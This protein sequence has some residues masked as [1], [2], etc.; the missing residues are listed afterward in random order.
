MR[1]ALL[2]IIVFSICSCSNSSNDNSLNSGYLV[3]KII[4]SSGS[5]SSTTTFSYS[6]NKLTESNNLN[7]KSTY[8][9][10]GNNITSITTTQ[11]QVLLYETFFTYD[12]NGRISSEMVNYYSYNF[13][14]KRV[15]TYNND[16][17]ISVVIYTGVIDNASDIERKAK[18][19]LDSVGEI[20]KIENYDLSDNL[21]SKSIYTNDGKN[22]PFKNIL[23]F[24]KQPYFFGRY[25]NIMTLDSFDSNNQIVTNSTFQYTY[26]SNNFPTSASQNFYNNGSLTSTTSIQYF[27]Q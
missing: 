21:T 11:A 15:Y 5:S 20:I 7:N 16:A 14:E 6:G 24:N 1:K 18:I 4:S 23:G 17:T 2:L 26:N 3:S 22:S 9:Y 19:Y 8:T 10:T 12:S 13:S 25:C 27:Y